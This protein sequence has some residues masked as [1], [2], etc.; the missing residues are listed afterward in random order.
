MMMTHHLN[1]LSLR[2]NLERLDAQQ[3]AQLD[4]HETPVNCGVT[5]YRGNPNAGQDGHLELDIYNQKLY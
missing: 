5:I 1:I 4:E 3:F 2:A